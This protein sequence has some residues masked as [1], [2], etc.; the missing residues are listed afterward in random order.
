[1]QPIISKT[2]NEI[3][4]R[5]DH[6]SAAVNEKVTTVESRIND[7]EQYTRRNRQRFYGFPESLT[8]NTNEIIIGYLSQELNLFDVNA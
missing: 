8:E 2:C 7:L 6:I 5:N 3:L 1:M 4:A